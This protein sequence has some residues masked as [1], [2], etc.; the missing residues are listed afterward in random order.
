MAGNCAAR[1]AQNLDHPPE[2][3]SGFA[4]YLAVRLSPARAVTLLH[5]LAAIL[6]AGAASPA[7]VL[8]AARRPPSG[9]PGTGA[10]A[11]A[12]EAF[13]TSA[14]L[15]LPADTT[16]QAA[17]ARQGRVSPRHQRRSA[18][19]RPAS[20]TPSCAT[21]TAPAGPEHGPGPT[22]PWRSTSPRS[23]TSPATWPLRGPQSPGGS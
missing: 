6:T 9:H 23:V 4:G 17:A 5:Q 22:A 14:R 8:A 10:L 11:R 2:W 3:L 15:T 12:L 18:R 20:A 19:P 1:L 13:F 16:A 7:A 21:A